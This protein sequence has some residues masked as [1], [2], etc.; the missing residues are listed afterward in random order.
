MN[1]LKPPSCLNLNLTPRA[2]RTGF[3]QKDAWTRRRTPR[4]QKV[5]HSEAGRSNSKTQGLSLHVGNLVR[6]QSIPGTRFR[7]RLPRVYP[8][9]AVFIPSRLVLQVYLVEDELKERNPEK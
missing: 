3:R 8:L 5:K 1:L 4:A 6:V 7:L 9:Q 2:E